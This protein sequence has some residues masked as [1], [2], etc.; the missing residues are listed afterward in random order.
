M[1]WEWLVGLAGKKT[2][3]CRI[4]VGNLKE[5]NHLVDLDVNGMIKLEWFLKKIL[6]ELGTD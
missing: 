5:R 2:G 3:A 4:V 1:R 6:G